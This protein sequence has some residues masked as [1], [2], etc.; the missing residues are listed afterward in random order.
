MKGRE[1][2]QRGGQGTTR[3]LWKAEK[4]R[5]GERGKERG[6]MKQVQEKGLRTLEQEESGRA[7]FGGVLGSLA[8]GGHEV[9][10]LL[11]GVAGTRLCFPS[12]PREGRRWADTWTPGNEGDFIIIF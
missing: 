3:D 7:A 5:G 9:S 4:R 8:R 1:A 2:R 12:G 10:V 11:K 6:E